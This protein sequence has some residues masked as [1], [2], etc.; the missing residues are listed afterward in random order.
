VA[1]FHY[2]LACYEC[3]LGDIDGAKERLRRTFEIDADFR[4]IALEDADLKPLWELLS[5]ELRE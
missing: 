5:L 4:E 1:I 2:N 3:Q